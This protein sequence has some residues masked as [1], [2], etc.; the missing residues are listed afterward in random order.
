M[1]TIKSLVVSNVKRLRAVEID[2][3]GKP[4]VVVGGMNEAGK[5]SCLDSIMYA[6]GGGSSI[7]GEP[8]R[9]GAAKAEI[10]LTLDGEPRLV[11]R[12]KFKDGKST[13]EVTE[14]AGKGPIRLS[15]PQKVL[16]ALC[17]RVAFDPLMFTRLRP[18]DQVAMLKKVVGIDTTEIDNSIEGIFNQ[19]TDVGRDVKA[20]ENMYGE[21]PRDLENLPDGPI[22]VEHLY[23]KLNEAHKFNTKIDSD[24]SELE[25]IRGQV[26]G[27]DRRIEDARQEIARL[28]ES[29]RTFDEERNAV[30]AEGKTINARLKSVDAVD[31]D[32]VQAEIAEAQRINALLERGHQFDQGRR[33]LDDARAKH[34]QLTASIDGLRSD[35]MRMMSEAKWPVEGV[36]F[37]DDG[38]TVNGL[39][40]EQASSAQQLRVAVAIGLAENPKLRV[41]LIRDG[42]LLDSRS[43]AM[44]RDIATE[45]DAQLWLECVGEGD[46]CTVIIEDGE[47]ATKC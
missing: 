32:A 24:R 1:S 26:A 5:S 36:G 16:D 46:D 35:R 44:L 37:N 22:D 20:L 41:M 6:L 25:R 45:H 28:K 33:K 29:I 43:K 7:P 18:A 34:E 27:I 47:V 31:T 19:R 15:S 30:I 23:R 42:S 2:A 38:V 13:L 3:D 8:V 21:R 17:S 40:F 9:R 4:I 10:V 12:R 14:D 39:P 11:V